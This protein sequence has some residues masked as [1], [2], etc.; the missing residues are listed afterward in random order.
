MEGATRGEPAP[1]FG[2]LPQ[3]FNTGDC[4]RETRAGRDPRAPGIHAPLTLYPRGFPGG[5][6]QLKRI[7]L[8]LRAWALGL[9]GALR[10]PLGDWDTWLMPVT[11]GTPST[12]SADVRKK[13]HVS[14]SPS[15]G[16]KRRKCPPLQ[17]RPATPSE[18]LGA[19]LR[20]RFP[21]QG[22]ETEV[23]GDDTPQGHTASWCESR[24]RSPLSAAVSHR[25]PR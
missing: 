7:S 16:R 10:R 4:A 19:F 11:E 13:G 23:L 6:N 24:D 15:H 1:S 21:L 8:E 3:P 2:H 25:L 17:H 14:A 20:G 12:T 18:P 22:R 5:G 9:S